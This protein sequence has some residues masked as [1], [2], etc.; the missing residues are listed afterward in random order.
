[1]ILFWTPAPYAE[2]PNAII[3][4][5][6]GNVTAVSNTRSGHGTHHS[7]YTGDSSWRGWDHLPIQPGAPGGC[8]FEEESESSSRS[9]LI[10][11]VLE[12][13]RPAEGLSGLQVHLMKYWNFLSGF[14]FANHSY[15]AGKNLIQTKTPSKPH[16][17]SLFSRGG[18]ETLLVLHVTVTEE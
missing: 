5:S 8:A 3:T 1:M 9:T 11:A 18:E 15:T 14:C 6:T 16:N 10:S 12:K 7:R 2:A 4:T 13:D 17:L